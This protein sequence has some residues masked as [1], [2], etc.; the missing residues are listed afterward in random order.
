MGELG[1]LVLRG[2]RNSALALAIITAGGCRTFKAD[3]AHLRSS[4]DSSKAKATLY[5]AF[6]PVDEIGKLYIGVLGMLKDVFGNDVVVKPF[7]TPMPDNGIADELYC[8]KGS[9]SAYARLKRIS[10]DEPR[11]PS[12]IIE[13]NDGRYVEPRSDPELCTLLDRSEDCL[14]E[15]RRR[16]YSDSDVDIRKLTRNRQPDSQPIRY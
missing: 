14:D 7:C 15:A 4:V 13:Y 1:E 6:N 12:V 11:V 16:L 9:E 10:G 5:Y 2:I 3:S 8:E